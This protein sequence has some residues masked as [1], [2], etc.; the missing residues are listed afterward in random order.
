MKHINKSYISPID[1]KLSEFDQNHHPS[2]AQIDEACKYKS[3]IEKR[4]EINLE[5]GNK[6]N[7]IIDWLN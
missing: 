3:I 5:L 6:K 1:E 7:S 4:D 2:Q